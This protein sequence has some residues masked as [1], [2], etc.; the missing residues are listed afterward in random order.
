MTDYTG[1]I[2]AF[3]FWDADGKRLHTL[4]VQTQEGSDGV[5]TN[6]F[7][8]RHGAV[9]DG[10]GYEVLSASQ[11]PSGFGKVPFWIQDDEQ[12]TETEMIAGS[13]GIACSSSGIETESGEIGL[14][15]MQPVTGWFICELQ[16]S[17]DKPAKPSVRHPMA[18]ETTITDSVASTME[19][20]A[21]ETTLTVDDMPST[22]KAVELPEPLDHD[23]QKIANSEAGDMSGTAYVLED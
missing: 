12:V 18:A 6:P 10:V 11:I 16:S 20:T 4:P 19:G 9:L 2:T 17:G 5:P 13:V 22:P 21:T 14:D 23:K 1:W 15:T 3:G 7:G 8:R